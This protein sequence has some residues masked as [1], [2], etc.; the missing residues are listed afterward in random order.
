MGGV[1]ERI[2]RTVKEAMCR[3]IKNTALTDYQL[4][5]N[6]AEIEII[7][8]NCPLTHDSDHCEDTKR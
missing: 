7:S 8:K 6:F 5:T 1:W 4:Q 3:I 2:V